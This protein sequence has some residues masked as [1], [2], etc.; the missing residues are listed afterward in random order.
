MLAKRSDEELMIAYQLG[1]VEAFEELYSRHAPRV[2]GFLQ[3]RTGDKALAFHD[4]P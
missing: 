1:E 4:L 2:L 3:K